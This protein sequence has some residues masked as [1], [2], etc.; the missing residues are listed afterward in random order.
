[1]LLAAM[2]GVRWWTVTHGD[3][4]PWCVWATPT[5]RM[6]FGPVPEFGDVRDAPG[7][8]SLD[9]NWSTTAM[10]RFI[11]GKP[12]PT[13]PG[14]SLMGNP[15]L[16]WVGLSRGFTTWQSTAVE[17]IGP[18][19]IKAT[20]FLRNE[21]SRGLDGSCPDASVAG[22]WEFVDGTGARRRVTLRADGV[23]EANVGALWGVRDGALVLD[24]GPADSPTSHFVETFV[25]S[26]DHRSLDGSV[27][28]AVHGTKVD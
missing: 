5:G 18:D 1:V 12:G 6:T 10:Q 22:T 13:V 28:D 7:G 21:A 25:L 20:A 14:V 4:E 27:L 23:V 26:E 3:R 9:G 2:V 11:D 16:R 15:L 8:R 17:R 24:Y 19:G